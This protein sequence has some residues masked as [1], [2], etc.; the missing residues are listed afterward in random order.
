MTGTVPQPN[1]NQKAAIH[2]ADGPALLLAGP[3]AGKTL[4][5]TERVIRLIQESPYESF[6]VLGLTF[7]NRAAEEMTR[8]V[9]NRLGHD[10]LRVEISTFHG[11]CANQLRQHG[12]HVGIRHDFR[13][14]TQPSDRIVIL[15]D[16]ERGSPAFAESSLPVEQK[17]KLLSRLLLSEG[18]REA[19]AALLPG[20]P[21]ARWVDDYVEALGREN[22]LD[23]DSLLYWC[24]RLLRTVPAVARLA[25]IT[26]P[27][28]C[29]DEYQDT[30]AAQ[31]GLLRQICPPPDGNLF[32]VADDDQIIYEWNGASPERLR[33]LR[34]DYGMS[35]FDLPDSYRCPERIL[36]HANRLIGHN[37]NRMCSRKP[38]SAVAVS[39]CGTLIR[40]YAFASEREEVAW[41]ARDIEQRGVGASDCAVMARTTK[42]AELAFNVLQTNGVAACHV[43]RWQ[44][45]DSPGVR[46]ITAA[47]RLAAAP[48]HTDQ[49][50]QLCRSF[51]EATRVRVSVDN[52]AGLAE[53]NGGALLVGFTRAA[54]HQGTGSRAM[55]LL[56]SVEKQLIGRGDY[57]EFIQRSF[58]SYR[59]TTLTPVWSDEVRQATED[60]I[61]RWLD[62]D[63]RI[64]DDAVS[65][66]PLSQYLQEFELRAGAPEPQPGQVQCLTISQAKGKGFAHVYL[67]GLAEDLLPSF[68]AKGGGDEDRRIEEERRI[69]FV[70][71]TRASRTLTLSYARSYWRWP[72]A[73]SRFLGEMGLSSDVE[74]PAGIRGN[75]T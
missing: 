73:P 52:A 38:L 19:M 5:L 17:A 31:D 29:V 61:D 3:G 40:R 13:L 55:V 50:R 9:G 64:S 60:E 14:L 66:G 8:R 11:F 6:N 23:F 18:S 45:F 54:G 4:V 65:A 59:S 26:Y 12:T 48:T 42:L 25:R 72:K 36:R 53:M 22:L 37:R 47:L 49:L 10:R 71:I 21:G 51:F 28:V 41:V 43:Q 68:Y 74:R 56:E 15:K 69:C 30:N 62:V 34:A 2:W 58:E 32:A 46:F 63:S 27:Y 24:L 39:P 20:I 75:R 16:L 1:A 67:V 70:A 44:G 57:R 7:T 33:A 35:L